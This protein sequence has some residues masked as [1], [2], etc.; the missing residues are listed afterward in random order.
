MDTEMS[1]LAAYLL[2]IPITAGIVVVIVGACLLLALLVG[3]IVTTVLRAFHPS[4]PISPHE[5]ID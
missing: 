5:E 3:L 2:V 4:H 1:W